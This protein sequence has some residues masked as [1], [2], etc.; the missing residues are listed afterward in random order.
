[1]G[2][3]GELPKAPEK[4]TLFME[5]M[6]EATLNKAV[7]IFMSLLTTTTL[8][9]CE[10]DLT[11]FSSPLFTVGYSSWSDQHGKHMLHGTLKSTWS[12]ASR[13]NDGYRLMSFFATATECH[14][15]VSSCRARADPG[16]TKVL[17]RY[18]QLRFW[19]QR[20]SISQRPLP[21]AQCFRKRRHARWLPYCKPV[22]LT[23]YLVKIALIPR[24]IF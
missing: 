1:M 20:D 15:A 8:I 21:S 6:T 4:K 13:R 5:D 19:K 18:R 7:R 16:F 11:A 23:I 10:F 12:K 24:L 3:A 2:T 17:W 22:F 9:F 14:S